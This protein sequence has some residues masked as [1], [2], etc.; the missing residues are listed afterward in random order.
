MFLKSRGT[1]RVDDWQAHTQTSESTKMARAGRCAKENRDEQG[2]VPPLE[3]VVCD[4]WG[5]PD[6]GRPGDLRQS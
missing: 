6:D 5:H 4:G 3:Q 1:P 2:I